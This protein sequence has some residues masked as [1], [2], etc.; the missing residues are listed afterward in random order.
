MQASGCRPQASSLK[1]QASGCSYF[2]Q[3]L[4]GYFF[5]EMLE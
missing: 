4:A 3:A 1:P 5:F 2:K